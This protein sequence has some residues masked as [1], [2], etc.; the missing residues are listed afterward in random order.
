MI[1]NFLVPHIKELEKRGHYVECA[2]SETG[3]FYND[4]IDIH[5]IKMNK[6]NFKRTPYSFKNYLGYK[7]VCKIIKEKRFDTIFCHEPVGGAV[8]RLAGHKTKCKVVYMAHGFHFYKGAPKSRIFYYWIEKWLSKYTDTLITINQEDYALAKKKFCAKY[9]VKVNG[10]GVDTSKFYSEKDNIIRQELGLKK[11]TTIILSVGELIKRKNHI[12]VIN[13]LRF[14]NDS[15]LIYVIAGDGKLGNW[16]KRRI[17]KMGL[18]DRVFLL[19]YRKDISRLCNSS[20]IFVLPSIHEGLSVAL[21][22]A[23]A[24]GLPVVASRIRGNVDLIDDGEGGYLVKTSDSF[25]Y[26]SSFQKLMDNNKR[27]QMGNYNK[28]K[29]LQFDISMVKEQIAHLFD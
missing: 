1:W 3:P 16:L 21:M 25:A 13:S 5:G 14:S 18:S 10:V 9:C 6:I 17:T 2:C 27:M 26:E 4:L 20:D 28:D 22:E 7:R 12:A 15:Q 24:C 23:M 11:D 19:G 8:G 29:L